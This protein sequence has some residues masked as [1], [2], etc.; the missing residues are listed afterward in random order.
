M[1]Y[2]CASSELDSF[3]IQNYNYLE[4]EI[5]THEGNVRFW[6]ETASIPLGKYWRSSRKETAGELYVE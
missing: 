4:K 5:A 3:F 1:S 6:I 2:T